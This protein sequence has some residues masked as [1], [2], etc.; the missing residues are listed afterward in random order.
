LRETHRVLVTMNRDDIAARA[1]APPTLWP[2]TEPA[3]VAPK[4]LLCGALSQ[5]NEM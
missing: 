3:F 2:N 5:A 1:E 4:D